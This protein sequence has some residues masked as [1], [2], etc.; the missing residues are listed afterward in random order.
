MA[1]TLAWF[2]LKSA[3]TAC[4]MAQHDLFFPSG[5][6]SNASKNVSN[7]ERSTAKSFLISGTVHL[8]VLSG[9][10]KVEVT[11][12][13]SFNISGSSGSQFAFMIGNV[14]CPKSQLSFSS[15][16]LW[17]CISGRSFSGNLL[18]ATNMTME[19][20]L[21]AEKKSRNVYFSLLRF[22]K[23]KQRIKSLLLILLMR[24]RNQNMPTPNNQS[25]QQ[26]LTRL[27]N[28][29]IEL[30]V[31][32]SSNFASHVIFSTRSPC[33]SGRTLVFEENFQLRMQLTTTHVS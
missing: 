33:R 1:N 32:T 10:R 18:F 19:V 26:F 21:P 27:N 14:N 17:T 29:L 20:H 11:F 30:A 9:F 22:C 4:D 25:N 2:Q 12:N 13:E 28:E 5:L 16:N 31:N 24:K 8:N 7:L 23:K 6:C 15:R 3:G